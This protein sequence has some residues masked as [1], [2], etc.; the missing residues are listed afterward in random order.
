M[1]ISAFE[2]DAQV[3]RDV[4]MGKQIPEHP[5]GRRQQRAVLCKAE[6]VTARARL[7][8][9]S[10]TASSQNN[11]DHRAAVEGDKRPVRAELQRPTLPVEDIL[12]VRLHPTAGKQYDGYITASQDSATRLQ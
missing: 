1:R 11:L 2:K 9:S 6:A 12:A 7:R 10:E 8:D 3:G 5:V 4:V